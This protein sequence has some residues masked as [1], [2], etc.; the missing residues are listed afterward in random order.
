MKKLLFL[1]LAAIF[2]F[3]LLGCG[4][5][6]VT[7]TI[8]NGKA[9]AVDWLDQKIADFEAQYPN[10]KVEQEYS[11]NAS[12]ELQ[13]KI[14]SDDIPDITT[15]YDTGLMKDG[16]YYDLS[17]MAVWSRIDPSIKDLCTDPNTGNQFRIATNRTMAGLFYNKDIF[18]E[19]GYDT[20]PLNWND[21]VTAL[22]AVKDKGYDP[23]Y[24]GGSETWML[25]HLIEFW[26]HGM[27]KQE[28]GNF[29]ARVA[30]LDNDQTKLDFNDVN[31]PMG[32]FATKFLELVNDGLFNSDFITASYDNQLDAFA[33]GDAAMISQG[34]WALN[35]I[36]EKNPDM[37]SNIGFM[38]Y[39]SMDPTLQPVILSAEDSGYSIMDASTHKDQA[40]TFLNYLFQANIQK[41]YSELIKEPS[42]FTDVDANWSPI[43]AEVASA[44]SAGV[45]IGFTDTP[46][47]FGG[48]E[49]GIL[50]QNLYTGDYT[51]QQFVTNYYNDWD[52]AWNA[53]N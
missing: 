48:D 30:F 49:A 40:I 15:V 31:G 43:K 4:Q 27:V 37:A 25:G 52:D 44:L 29:D 13:V 32:I 12:S 22:Q 51:V 28:L 33:T 19:A 53:S 7:I 1:V 21:F 45:H 41:E 35:T 50:V 5:K 6:T 10:I 14:S 47:G 39:P 3:S 42:A 26:A 9:E 2:S 24:M 11:D 20:V 16:Y 17:D 23:I 46:S 36:L 8:L 34:M 38:P 18:S